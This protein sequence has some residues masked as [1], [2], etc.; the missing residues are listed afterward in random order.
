MLNQSQDKSVVSDH[1]KLSHPQPQPQPQPHHI[2]STSQPHIYHDPHH[3]HTL[4]RQDYH[5]RHLYPPSPPRPVERDSIPERQLHND[6]ATNLFGRDTTVESYPSSSTTHVAPAPPSQIEAVSRSNNGTN[7]PIQ[8]DLL[9]HHP[10]EASTSTATFNTSIHPPNSPPSMDDTQMRELSPSIDTTTS[11]HDATITAKEIS[12]DPPITSD[13]LTIT[14]PSASSYI[15]QFSIPES[16]RPAFRDVLCNPPDPDLKIKKKSVRFTQS[17]RSP[18]GRQLP[19]VGT[20]PPSSS[21]LA[22]SGKKALSGAFSTGPVQLVPDK[23]PE[24]K[25]AELMELKQ[26]KIRQ[27]DLFHLK[28]QV[29]QMAQSLEDKDS[30]LDEVRAERKSLQSELSRYIAMVKQVQKDLELASQAETQLVTERDQLSLQLAQIRDTDYKILKEEVDQL[31]AKKGMRSLPTLEQEQAEVMGRYL[32]QRR[33]QWREDGGEGSSSSLFMDPYHANGGG[34]GGSSSVA[35]GSAASGSGSGSLR[36][37]A[38]SSSLTSSAKVSSRG[39]S[40]SS[41]RHQ[42][43]TS[44]SGDKARSGRGRGGG[45]S[46]RS[47]SPAPSPTSSARGERSRK[48]SRH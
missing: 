5:Q 48:R 47:Q 1:S 16:L 17:V 35:G 26:M 27:D 34:G 41:S 15:A 38:S 3:A 32:E 31:R 2:P 40:S 44:G 46:S 13:F 25:I 18:T 11:E 12:P 45:Q 20:F 30:I 43:E 4:L 36:K 8:P 39:A 33:G 29:F 6:L 14:E 22:S 28:E 21:P 42:R 7:T 10:S 23:D 24:E 9:H 37:S 19:P